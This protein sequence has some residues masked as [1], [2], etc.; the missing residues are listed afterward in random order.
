MMVESLLPREDMIGNYCLVLCP[1]EGVGRFSL[2]T[3]ILTNFSL[4]YLILIFQIIA[5]TVTHFKNL[6][7]K[8]DMT[9]K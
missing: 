3:K 1:R 7:Q 9:L 4:Y 8:L 2:K 5:K 6:Q